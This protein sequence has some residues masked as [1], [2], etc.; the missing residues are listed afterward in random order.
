MKRALATSG[1]EARAAFAKVG[2]L[3]ASARRTS[4]ALHPT[5]LHVNQ[6]LF[7]RDTVQSRM[8]DPHWL[9]E[10]L[11]TQI[12]FDKAWETKVVERILHNLSLL[13]GKSFASVQELNRYRKE[14]SA[15]SPGG[16]SGAV[17]AAPV[18]T[19]VQT[20]AQTQAQAQ[21]SM[22]VPDALSTGV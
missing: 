14:V 18:R 11:D 2:V 1:D 21:A 20:P 4:Q 19:P 3:M 16:A 5:N 17:T 12:K 6:A 9:E 8:P 15:K 7:P 10:W 13:L 22:P